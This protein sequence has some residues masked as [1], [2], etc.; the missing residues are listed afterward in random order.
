MIV[1]KLD[2]NGVI[3]NLIV[4]DKAED[5]PDYVVAPSHAAIGQTLV[6]AIALSAIVDLDYARSAR[7]QEIRENGYALVDSE[8][9]DERQKMRIQM[10]ALLMLDEQTR[11]GGNRGPELDVIVAKA[12]YI[13][14]IH[15]TIDQAEV[16]LQTEADPENYS[17]VWP[18]NPVLT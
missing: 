4:V 9:G 6:E 11:R 10:N 1:A 17:V 5:A 2:I 12:Q 7:L 14:A 15:Q 18:S 8:V 13:E 3:E 16:D